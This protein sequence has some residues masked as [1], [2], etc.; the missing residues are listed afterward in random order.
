MHATQAW[1]LHLHHTMLNIRYVFV[2]ADHCIYMCDTA[3]GLSVIAVHVNNMCAMASRMSEMAKL[4]VWLGS[5]L[6]WL[7]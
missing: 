7:T 3:E 2:M 4:K 6:V 1:N 5:F